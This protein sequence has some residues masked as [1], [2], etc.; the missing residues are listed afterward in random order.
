MPDPKQNQGV[1]I[2]LTITKV[3]LFFFGLYFGVG[4]LA[5]MGLIGIE[6]GTGEVASDMEVSSAVLY[7]GL[8]L[9]SLTCAGLSFLCF[10]GFV[11]IRRWMRQSTQETNEEVI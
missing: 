9:F 2:L 7:T 11:R 5:C 3:V 6:A 1:H 10:F 8:S 4:F